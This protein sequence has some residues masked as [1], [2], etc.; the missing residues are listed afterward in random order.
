MTSLIGFLILVGTVVNNGILY[1]DA[2]NQ[3]R[4]QMSITDALIE[5][6]ATRL[7]PI[8]M[9]TMTTVFSMLPMATAYGS[10]GATTQGLAVVDIGG[11]IFGVAVALFILPVYYLIINGRK[12]LSRLDI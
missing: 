10:S 1:V 5:A 8:L 12:E 2:V 11:L 9:T 6:G 7:R 4:T 3:E